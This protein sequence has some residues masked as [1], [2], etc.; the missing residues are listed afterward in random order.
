MRRMKILTMKNIQI[1]SKIQLS[2]FSFEKN[3]N[4]NMKLI[5]DLL[6]LNAFENINQFQNH[7]NS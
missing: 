1:F 4:K 6:N 7:Q 5:C 2:K 3:K